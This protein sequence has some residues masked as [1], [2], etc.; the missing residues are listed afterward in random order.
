MP[1]EERAGVETLTSLGI[2]G[3]FLAGLTGSVHCALMCGP[4]AC[5]PQSR[6]AGLKGATLWHFGRLTS[7]ALVGL[8]LGS[9]GRSAL[10]LVR[11]DITPILPWVMATGLVLT[12]FDFG[13]KLPALPGVARIAR[14][15]T[16]RASPFLLGA[17][18][19]FLPCG[20]LYGMFI[21]AAA[22]ANP[23]SGAA[24]LATFALASAPALI[25]VQFGAGRIAVPPLVRRGV[26]LG[27]AAIL[28]F[29]A[30]ST[31]AEVTHCG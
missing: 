10:V 14:F 17:A 1:I 21:A 16:R 15:L 7:Y 8:V 4:L 25:A 18:T 30:L 9:V 27:A 31:Q 5:I 26:L 19:P 20:L 24:L 6:G 23:L 2:A 22:S 3:A 12:A 28:I 11:T 29:R 13:R